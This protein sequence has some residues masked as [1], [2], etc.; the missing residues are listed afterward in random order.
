VPLATSSEEESSSRTRSRGKHVEMKRTKIGSIDRQY[1]GASI[2]SN[3]R[4][5]S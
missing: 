1:V 2:E 5:Q 4:D 3:G